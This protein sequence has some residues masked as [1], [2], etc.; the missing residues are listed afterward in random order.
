M[1]SPVDNLFLSAPDVVARQTAA[2]VRRLLEA[3]AAPLG[4]LQSPHTQQLIMMRASTRWLGM[5]I[6]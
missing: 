6:D 5:T 4:V 3:V 2:S 1:P